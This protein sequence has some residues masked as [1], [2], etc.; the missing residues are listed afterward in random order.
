MRDT[1]NK[2][3]EAIE[4]NKWDSFLKSVGDKPVE[5]YHVDIRSI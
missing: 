5:A 2:E 4:N 1:I 3:I